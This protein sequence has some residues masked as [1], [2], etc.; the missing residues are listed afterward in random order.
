MSQNF[1]D[2]GTATRQ[3]GWHKVADPATGW[4]ASKTSG[5]TADSFSGG[6]TVDFSTVVP[7]GTR[8]VRVY[9]DAATT[10]SIVSWRAGSDSNIS[11]TPQASGENAHQL[12]NSSDGGA[13]VVV[14]LSAAYTVDF[15]VAS[16]GTDLYVSYPSEYLL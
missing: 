7:V 14:W 9:I 12:F 4:F 3:P 6:L 16:T 2:I 1:E 8:A 15:A 11:N 5:W 10:L 13:V